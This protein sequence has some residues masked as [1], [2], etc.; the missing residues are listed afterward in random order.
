LSLSADVPNVKIQCVFVMLAV[1]A[2]FAAPVGRYPQKRDPARAEE[3]YRLRVQHVGRHERVFPAAQLAERH[4]A[5]RV[6]EGLLANVPDALYIAHVARVLRHPRF[7]SPKP[8]L[9]GGQ[10][11]PQ[12]DAANPA[13]GD[14]RA[15]LA[16]LASG[17]KLPVGWILERG[18]Q[19]RL[20]HSGVNVVLRVRLLSA[21][22]PQYCLSASVVDANFR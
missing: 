21:D 14:E 15:A 4:L 6:D 11:V 5:V 9:E 10:I 7:K 19:R 20:F 12:P 16:K 8:P 1:P 3:R 18:V 17:T 2:A 13:R 22:F